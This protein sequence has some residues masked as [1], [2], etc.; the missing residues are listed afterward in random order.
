[1]RRLPSPGA[2]LGGL[3]LLVALGG[4]SYAAISL[5]ANS[6][7]TKQLKA[8]AVVTSK[9]KDGSLKAV[10]FAPGQ[11]P[12]GSPG[13]PGAPGPAGPTGAAGPSDAYSKFTNGPVAVPAALTT[14]T[15][16]SI[17]QGGNYVIVG[18]MWFDGAGGI[19]TCQLQAGGDTD[20]TQT[21][22]ATGTPEGTK[23]LV[24]HTFAG[25]DSVNY[26]CS[27]TGTVAAHDI[28]VT[29]I[30]VGNSVNTS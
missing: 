5:P 6:V 30:R 4:T 20:S 9:V 18:K 7:G 14:L 16:L 12:A 3:A 8:N 21:Y 17:P 15:S 27:A 11:I 19:A 23:N 22:A 28:K 10:D 29:A 25:A 13:A 26:K 1:M 24:V 2:V